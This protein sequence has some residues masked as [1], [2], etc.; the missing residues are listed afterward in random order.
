MSF[1][2]KTIKTIASPIT[3][4]ISLA[5]SLYTRQVS[6]VQGILKDSAER[7]KSQMDVDLIAEMSVNR[8]A[9]L[10]AWG[11]EDNKLAINKVNRGLIFEAILFAV[12][13]IIPVIGIIIEITPMNTVASFSTSPLCLYVATTKVWRYECIKAGRLTTYWRWL[14]G[15][16][17]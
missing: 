2:K 9:L 1:I 10:S 3:A 17:A 8:L 15:K 16:E 14:S 12:I 11:I 5:Q 13:A 7:K 4:P 6:G